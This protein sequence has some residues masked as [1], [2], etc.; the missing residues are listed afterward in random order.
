MPLQIQNFVNKSGI[1]SKDI[2]IYI[3]EL[4]SEKVIASLNSSTTRKPASVIKV[5]TTYST[6]LKLGFNYRWPTEFYANGSIGAGV[7]NGNLVVKGYG[8]PTLAKKHIASIVKKIKN[9][10]VRRI[11]GDIIIDRS[12]FNVGNKNSSNFDKY[13]YSPYNAMPDAM[14]FNERTSTV[15]ITPKKKSASKSINDPSYSV[16]NQIKYVNTACKGKYSWIGSRVDMSSGN[17]KLILNGKL[18][19]NCGTRK[20]CKVITKPYKAFYHALRNALRKNSISVGGGFRLAKV[21]K[22]SKLLFTHY[23]QTLE[24]IISKTAKKSNNLYARQLMLHLGAKVYGAPATLNKGRKAIKYILKRYNALASSKL[25][26]ENGS[27]LS[28]SSNVTAEIFSYMFQSAY[29]RYG[30]RWMNTLSIGGKDGTIRKRFRGSPASNHSWMKTGTLNRVKNI[31]GYVKNR[32]GKLYTVVILVNTKVG[33]WKASHLQNKIINWIAKSKTINLKE[34]KEV[35]VEEKVIVE[36]KV[37]T[38]K[39]V[40]TEKKKIIIK[41][42]VVEKKKVTIK[43]KTPVKKTE[44]FIFNPKTSTVEKVVPKRVIPKKIT[45]KKTKQSSTNQT[46]YYIQVGL[47]SHRPNSQYYAKIDKLGLNYSTRYKNEYKVLI[48][49]YTNEKRARDVLKKVK[50]HLTRKAF[51]VKNQ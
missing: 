10:G 33:R 16:V 18:S 3:K 26:I 6:L 9:S 34:R 8:D 24:K 40:S 12:Y 45:P 14:M 7:L 29:S 15:C 23:S 36:K 50:R 35:N 37:I 44:E 21:P 42:K 25:Y 39:K 2:S 20:V 32:S 31:G 51:L 30:Q 41:K 1:P 4:E 43:K 5:M 22:G 11:T 19:K 17:P 28:R 48:G 27:G 46:H 47:F 38:E 13:T 49:P